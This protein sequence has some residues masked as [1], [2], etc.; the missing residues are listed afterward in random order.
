MKTTR[1]KIILSS[2]L[3][4]AA[5]LATLSLNSGLAP[6]AVHDDPMGRTPASLYEQMRSGTIAVERKLA[7]HVAGLK[8]R[9]LAS[10]GRP[11]NSLEHLRFG[12]LEGKYALAMNGETVSEATFIN[13]PDSEGRPAVVSNRTE[14][15][16]NFASLFDVKGIPA[17]VSV[18]VLGT[19][20]V[21]TYRVKSSK[22]DEE[23]L[24]SFV[25]DDTDHLVSLKS[26]KVSVLNN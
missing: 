20:V 26:E 21:E 24:L 8:S 3:L 23:V 17:R 12:V 4:G 13:N 16:K 2:S 9:M 6:E 5:L 18:D 15:I 22:A 7:S 11:P 10:I 1:L 19:K 14:F 25:L